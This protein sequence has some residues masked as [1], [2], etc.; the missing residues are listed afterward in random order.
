MNGLSKQQLVTLRQALVDQFNL[1]IKGQI[2]LLSNAPAR[3][4]I[5]QDILKSIAE[6]QVADLAQFKLSTQTTMFHDKNVY[7]VFYVTDEKG[8]IIGDT[9]EKAFNG[10]NVSS[11]EVFTKAMGGTPAVGEVLKSKAEGGASL[12]I[13]AP[14]KLQ[15]KTM[16]ILGA[17]WKLDFLSVGPPVGQNLATW[18][19]KRPSIGRDP[20][21][22]V[23][24]GIVV[25]SVGGL[26]KTG[27]GLGRRIGGSY[28]DTD[29]DVEF[30][31]IIAEDPLV[32]P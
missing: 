1:L 23:S 2:D 3:D 27:R 13:A 8:K 30:L 15:D 20:I 29:G 7:E 11:Q 9:C 31:P 26:K 19:K 21:P 4:S 10:I 14:A 28:T 16:G 5:I 25:C 6:T 12:V 22:P 32:H 17:H 18:S 24:F